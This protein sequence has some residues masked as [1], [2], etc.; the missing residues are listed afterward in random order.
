MRIVSTKLALKADFE[1]DDFYAILSSWFREN[2]IYTA[3]GEL[4]M[5]AENKDNAKVEAQFSTVE[6]FTAERNGVDYLLF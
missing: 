1:K 6:T 4:F 3:V 5:L 2:K